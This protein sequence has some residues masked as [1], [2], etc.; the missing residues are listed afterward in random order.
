MCANKQSDGCPI[1][2]WLPLEEI[3]SQALEQLNN[4]SRLPFVKSI[5]V[6]PDVHSGYGVPIGSVVV[7][8]GA[9]SPASIGVDIG[10]GMSAMKVRIDS[11]RV[12]AEADI[13]RHSI[14][15]SIPTGFNQHKQDVNPTLGLGF[16]RCMEKAKIDPEKINLQKGTLGG[17]NHFIELCLDE[18]HEVWVLIHTGSRNTGL[19]IANHYID[20]AKQLM[21]KYFINLPDPY[22]AYLSQDTPE[23]DDYWYD[24]R[25][26]QGYA[27]I[28]RSTILSLIRG[29]LMHFAKEEV[30]FYSAIDC[31]HNYAI[32]EGNNIIVRK[33]AISVKQGEMGII[34][35]SMGAKSYIVEGLGNPDSFMSSSHGAGRKMGRSAAKKA[36]TKEDLTKAMEGISYDKDAKI[37]DEIPQ[38]Y[39]DIDQVMEYQ[40]D[41]VK[42][43]H[44][45][46]QIL[47]IKGSE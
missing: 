16:P 34:P 31:H 13:L 8:Q 10:C 47:S 26:A 44:V 32:M 4:A 33:G 1:K 45:L 11:D 39:K 36:F 22:L 21:S 6:M 23:F 43:V 9:V 18:N 2:Y 27:F 19:K 17:G 38:A 30:Y 20:L 46:K 42:P 14:E 12:V 28:N 7:S 29:D 37:L 24:L 41:L 40:K 35:G 3:E 5:C 25:W 15:R